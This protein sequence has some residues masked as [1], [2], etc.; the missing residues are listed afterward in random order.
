MEI[1][2]KNGNE[3][4]TPGFFVVKRH[5]AFKPD[6]A[7]VRAQDGNAELLMLSGLGIFPIKQCGPALWSDE[8]L[9]EEY[10]VAQDKQV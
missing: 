5:N 7:E 8:V 10:P 6:I 3:P 4:R 9:F 1:Q 2:L